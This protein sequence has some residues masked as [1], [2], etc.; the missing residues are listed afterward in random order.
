[1]TDMHSD[2]FLVYRQ[3]RFDLAYTFNYQTAQDVHPPLDCAI[4]LYLLDGSGALVAQA[5]GPI[6]HYDHAIVPT[7]QMQPGQIYIDYRALDLSEDLPPGDYTLM[8][9]V[10]QP[11]DGVRLTL[12]GGADMAA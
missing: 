3:T 5:D 7:S 1:M 4:G 12:P 6:N 8:L 2:E 9:A 10:Y 11:W